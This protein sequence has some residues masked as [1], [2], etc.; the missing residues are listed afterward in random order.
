MADGMSD[1]SGRRTKSVIR[2]SFPCSRKQFQCR[3]LG[4]IASRNQARHLTF[5]PQNITIFCSL[6]QPGWT[7]RRG[8]S[9]PALRLIGELSRAVRKRG[10]KFGVFIHGIENF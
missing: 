1:I 7:V 3:C 2:I 5:P 9:G 6:G 10:L 8:E 4:G